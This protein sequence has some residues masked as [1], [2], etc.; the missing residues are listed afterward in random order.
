MEIIKQDPV[1]KTVAS[2]EIGCVSADC[3]VNFLFADC[4]ETPKLEREIER[5]F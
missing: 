3:T 1:T 2:A 4:T 5:G